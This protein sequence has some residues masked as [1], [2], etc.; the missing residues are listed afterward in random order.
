MET[1][2]FFSFSHPPLTLQ[3]LLKQFS[4]KCFF[5]SPLSR[6]DLLIVSLQNVS[7][8]SLHSTWRVSP[9]K[10]FTIT[11]P[12]SGVRLIIVSNSIW[13]PFHLLSWVH[14]ILPF[15][16]SVSSLVFSVKVRKSGLRA[17]KSVEH[18]DVKDWIQYRNPGGKLVVKAGGSQLLDEASQDLKK[19]GGLQ[20]V[21]WPDVNCDA[22]QSGKIL[23]CDIGI[24]KGGFLNTWPNRWKTRS[25]WHDECQTSQEVPYGRSP[26]VKWRSVTQ[27]DNKKTFICKSLS[28][29]SSKLKSFSV[30]GVPV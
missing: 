9:L 12:A 21:S 14:T 11:P 3:D 22:A 4:Q 17:T 20:L 24:K 13:L 1:E 27:S 10:R 5:Q 8:S 15:I 2:Q 16:V 25:W 26:T 23:G 28:S 7:F 6:D 29:V 30:S 18:H 19:G